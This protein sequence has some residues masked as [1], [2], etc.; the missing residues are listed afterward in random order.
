M[1]RVSLVITGRVHGVGFRW[2]VL[3]VATALELTGEVRNRAD[4]AVEVEAEGV[5]ERLEQLVES[6]REGPVT[7]MVSRVDVHWGE[8]P[9]RYRDFR[10]G[11]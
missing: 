9:A 8:G 1:H 10:V 6:A 2:Y 5:R 4:G 3:R 11:R 7:A